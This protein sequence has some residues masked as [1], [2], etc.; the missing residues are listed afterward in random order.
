MEFTEV[1]LVSPGLSIYVPFNGR[2]LKRLPEIFVR[3]TFKPIAS[4]KFLQI[5]G[6]FFPID[7]VLQE[8]GGYMARYSNEKFAANG[9]GETEEEA[10]EDI[11]SA[12]ELLLEEETNSSRDLLWPKEFQ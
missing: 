10:L 7:V 12:I 2:H 5:Q 9:Q 4:M 1:T 6:Q 11:R 8:E 3:Q